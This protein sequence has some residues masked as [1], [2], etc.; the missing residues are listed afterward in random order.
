MPTVPVYQ[1]TEKQRPILRQGI[2]VQASPNDF[3]AQIGQGLQSVSQGLEN[4]GDVVSRVR[5]IQATNAAKDHLTAMEREKMELDY[6]PNGFLTKQG[7]AAVDG[8]AGYDQALEELKKKY[9]PQDAVAA[10]KY[11]DAATAVVTQGMR[12]GI[13][14]AAQG[15]KDWAASSSTARME[16]FKDQ[17][18]AGYDKPDEI[19]KSLALGAAEINEQG[20]LMGWDQ[21]VLDLK[22]QEFASTVHSNVALAIASKPNGARSALEYIKANGATMDAKTKLDMESKLRPFA[23]DEEGLSVVNEI[24]TGKRK[25]ADLPGDIVGEV[26][27]V[28]DKTNKPV[29]AGGGPTR[30]KAFLSSISANKD[31]P[32]DTL[33]LDDSFADN[34][35]AMIQDAPESVRK[36]LGVGS[37]WRSNER[38]KQLFANSDG[39]GRMVAF[40]AGYEKPDGSIAKGSKHLL[41]RAVDMT[42]NGQRLDK[43]P[44]E[45]RDWVHSNAANYGLRFPMSWEPWHIEPTAAS[46]GGSTVVPSRDGIAARTSMP[47]YG[48]AMERI[49][50]IT[51]PEVK[52]SAMKQ[53]NAQF[54]MRA[55]AETANS[56]VAKTQ[57]FT[58]MMQN[59]PFSQIPLDLKI[60]A[61]REAVSGFMDF[62]SKAGDVKTDPVAYNSLSTM[63]AAAPETFKTVDMTAPEVINSL[64]RED[65][66]ALSNK[67]SSILGDEAKAVREGTVYTQAFTQ[68]KQTLE[69]VGLTTNGIKADAGNKRIE[70]ELRIARF[71][72]ELRQRIDDYQT[73][74][75][76]TPTYSDTQALINELTLPIVVQKPGTLWGTS[77]TE[78]QFFFE[79]N[80]REDGTAFEVKIPYEDI[81]TDLRD[82]IKS[83]LE[84]TTGRK[85]TPEEVSA[86]YA[87]FLLGR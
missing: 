65:W 73:Q 63:A 28:P 14:H 36:G 43:A 71:Q 29:K 4:V 5:D 42:Y 16:L 12:S 53:L 1:R 44:Q 22:K 26:A 35:H 83:S 56:D 84:A 46:R 2:D 9:Q 24:I 74:T 77:E 39:T 86:E 75:G 33:N 70:M 18:L 17:A 51:D 27:G 87:K 31:R 72:N 19:K 57:I 32:G 7:Q 55:K 30:A 78:G 37:A 21:S 3:G 10:K 60:A 20:R 85:P 47:S 64:S 45:V 48:E 41:G 61:G 40:P 80:D 58:M 23:A 66:K 59:T 34:L 8:R 13:M 68:A 49:N 67:Q 38:Q 79:A 25:V 15:Q 62:E 11:G 82:R 54:E 69:S 52:A 76:K 6:G 81:P 50:Q